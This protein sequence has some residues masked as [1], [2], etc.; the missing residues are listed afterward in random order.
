MEIINLFYTT[1]GKTYAES[2]KRDMDS[3]GH[4]YCQNN[5]QSDQI[6]EN[7]CRLYSLGSLKNINTMEGF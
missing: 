3:K 1:L 6:H 5:S 7:N 4:G 2:W